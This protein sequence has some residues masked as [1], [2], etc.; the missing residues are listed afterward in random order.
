MNRINRDTITSAAVLP[1]ADSYIKQSLYFISKTELKRFPQQQ[2][3]PIEP[4]LFPRLPSVLSKTKMASSTTSSSKRLR[5]PTIPRH[6]EEAILHT[7]FQNVLDHRSPIQMVLV[8]GG[9]GTG[10]STLVKRSLASFQAK[11]HHYHSGSSSSSNNNNNNNSSSPLFFHATT[12]FDQRQTTAPL[13]GLRQLVTDLIQAAHRQGVC[14]DVVKNRLT[15]EQIQ[16][17][18]GF[19]VDEG[20]LR[21]VQ[22]DD[23]D[24]N[25]TSMNQVAV[26]AAAVVEESKEVDVEP[27][28]PKCLTEESPES[29]ELSSED[30]SDLVS[31]TVDD[32]SKDGLAVLTTTLKAYIQ[33]VASVSPVLLQLEGLQWGCRTTMELLE[34]IVTAGHSDVSEDYCMENLC[35][36]ATFR[37]NEETANDHFYAWKDELQAKFFQQNDTES[38]REDTVTENDIKA[39]DDKDV[40]VDKSTSDYTIPLSQ[41]SSNL[42]VLDLDNLELSHVQE[43]LAEAT[44]REMSD[45]EPL[46]DVVFKF[47]HGN[48]FFLRHFLE[49]LQDDGLLVFNDT[50]FRWEW[51][52]EKIKR[53]S[54]ISSNVVQVL[55]SRLHKLPQSV[56][57]VLMLAAC[58]GNQ[59]DVRALEIAKTVFDDI[60]CVEW[61]LNQAAEQ[62]FVIPLTTST[63]GGKHYKFCH[64][65]LQMTAYGLVPEEVELG[66]V[67]WDIGCLLLEK[68]KHLWQTDDAILFSTVDHVN[69]GVDWL[70]SP[71]VTSGGACLTKK[72][73]INVAKINYLAG[74]KAASLS[75]FYPAATY[76]KA[77]IKALGGCE[78]AA[79]A[80]RM[81]YPL[82]LKMFDLYA[83]TQYC[84]G[85]IDACR[86][87]ANRVMELADTCGEKHAALSLLIKCYAAE[88]DPLELLNFCSGMLENLGEK[89]NENP[90]SVSVQLEYQKMKHR[91]NNLSDEEI[92]SLPDITNEEK[93]FALMM[94]SHLIFPLYQME[95]T[96]TSTL[97]T[98]RMVQLTLKYGMCGSSADAF[99]MAATSFGGI[100]HDIKA[101]YRLAQ[102]TEKLVRTRLGGI[103]PKNA[104]VMSIVASG[105]KWWFEPVSNS[106]EI[107]VE[108]H[109]I[110]MR[111]G[112]VGLGFQSII[113]YMT[114]YYYTGLPLESLLEDTEK[115][116]RLFLDYNHKTHFLLT[117]PL[118]QCCKSL[119]LWILL[120]AGFV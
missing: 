117:L 37:T 46:A 109:K 84:V 19:S 70:E 3:A 118:W 54:S 31:V 112:E 69:I 111:S 63:S 41:A 5:L 45:I 76:M 9:S 116:A 50:F 58:F 88:N 33:A 119:Y 90:S 52:V 95:R 120:L 32:F 10:K 62:E 81:C 51:D 68:G 97:L 92:L 56:Q 102:L 74:A 16:V 40:K 107:F 71:T 113:A 23:N 29:A 8:G 108:S 42:H 38:A 26:V 12:K 6:E 30:A 96:G 101:A 89:I 1:E 35:V 100:S 85:D 36:V 25:N 20:V 60:K 47:T 22:F 48:L 86:K 44:S 7:A 59:F 28:A 18:R 53:R 79:I 64:D 39:S 66:K 75:A 77:G 98:C 34:C 106:L 4:S 93:E 114:N 73:R 61:C 27:E 11:H 115:Y 17:M 2:L 87:A 80:F 94:M 105:S 83:K 21:G 82:A 67:H 24:N 43:I 99:S 13:A 49:K 57:N 72:W 65:M 91:L 15:P 14:C 78:D 55:A 103:T 104:Q 110:C